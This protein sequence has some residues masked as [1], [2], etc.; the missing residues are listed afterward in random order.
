MPP[1]SFSQPTQAVHSR[2][3]ATS[4]PSCSGSRATSRLAASSR[5]SSFLPSSQWWCRHSCCSSSSKD[6]WKR[7]TRQKLAMRSISHVWNATWCSSSVWA[8]SS[9]CPSSV[10]SRVCLLSWASCSCWVCSGASRNFSTA[11]RAMSTRACRCA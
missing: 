3:S 9:S 5:N 10:S 6:S 4:R 2:P 8:A 11:L 7:T 1:A